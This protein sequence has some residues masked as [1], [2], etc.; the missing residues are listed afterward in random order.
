[1]TMSNL[2]QSAANIEDEYDRRFDDEYDFGPLEEERCACGAPADDV[3][4][5]SVCDSPMCAMCHEGCLGICK[6]CL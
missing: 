5:C 6:A 3:Y 4:T 1:M 2:W